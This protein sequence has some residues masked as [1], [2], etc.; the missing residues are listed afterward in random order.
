MGRQILVRIASSVLLAVLVLSGTTASGE[1]ASRACKDIF[2]GVA[3][4]HTVGKIDAEHPEIGIRR[5]ATGYSIRSSA[6]TQSVDSIPA[7][8]AALSVDVARRAEG[9]Q[10]LELYFQDMD[11]REALNL[12]S[13]LR[14]RAAGGTDIEAFAHSR[15]GRA[16]A[17]ADTGE[18]NNPSGSAFFQ[19]LLRRYD[20]TRAR[21]Q[22]VPPASTPMLAGF[23][24]EG[25]SFR[26]RVPAGDGSPSTPFKLSVFFK[27]LLSKP[28]SHHVASAVEGALRQETMNNATVQRAAREIIGRI[29][30][31][32]P[33]SKALIDVAD[34]MI[35]EL[36]REAVSAND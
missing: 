3:G 28:S 32:F 1:E 23:S 31:T 17:T 5:T 27:D 10:S 25:Y 13:T 8:V 9:R 15:G 16:Q 34:L 2:A 19:P 20:W 21:I 26:I 24:P 18:V 14:L 36:T 33:D 4:Q 7:L 11:K 35:V 6:G 29:E 30:A 12:V 22:E